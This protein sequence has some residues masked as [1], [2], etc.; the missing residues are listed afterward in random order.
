MTPDSGTAHPAL[1]DA[2]PAPLPSA[3][4]ATTLG[5][6]LAAS[7][8]VVVTAT[9]LLPPASRSSCAF[10]FAVAV[11]CAG[12]GNVLIASAALSRDPRSAATTTRALLVDFAVHVILGGGIAVALFLLR[13]K[14][15]A[16]A[17]FALAFA[18]SAAVLRVVGAGVLSRAL[19]SAASRPE[20][21]R[22]I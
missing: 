14:F 13:T 11:V 9:G 4:R 21:E 6:L 20:P 2:R 8:L 16:P 10:G 19:K 22:R 18:A 3:L 17:A 7:I 1:P 12:L 5:A 15:L